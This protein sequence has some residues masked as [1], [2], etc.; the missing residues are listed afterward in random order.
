MSRPARGPVLV[1]VDA[2][3]TWLRAVVSR[4]GR[5]PLRRRLP[6]PA[7]VPLERT[8]RRAFRL[9]GVRRADLLVLGCKGVWGAGAREAL[10]ARLKGLARRASVMSDLELAWEAAFARGPGVVTV[11]GTGSAAFARDAS[12]RR[13]RAGGLGPLLGDEGSA[14]WIGRRWLALGPEGRALRYAR[15]PDAVAAVAALARAVCRRAPLDPRARAILR[16]GAEELARTTSR[17]A[18]ALKLPRGTPL[19]CRGGMFRSADFRATFLRALR[20]DRSGLRPLSHAPRAEDAVFKFAK[21]RL[22]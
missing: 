17:A 7:G 16:S 2:G 18:G 20:A 21:M 4:P 6:S 11:A 9:L 5:P 14:F 15:R 8:L 12:G 19:C 22:P 13:A 10:S 3:G 1:G